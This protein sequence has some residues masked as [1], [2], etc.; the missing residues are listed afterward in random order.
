MSYRRLTWIG[1][2]AAILGVVAV[3]GA[4]AQERNPGPEGPAAA[5]DEQLAYAFM[6][7]SNSIAVIDL[8]G[9][10]ILARFSVAGNPHG[11]T[12]TPD[13]RFIYTASMGSEK[14]YVV[15]ARSGTTLKSIELGSISHHSAVSRDGRYVY[16]AADRVVVIDT[17][18][19]EVVERI[20]TEE[21]PFYLEFTPDGR[22]LFA[23]GVG[24]SIAVIDPSENRV[25]DTIRMPARS[26]MGHSAFRPDGKELYV[27]NDADDMV[28]VIDVESNKPV[29]SIPVGRGPHGVASTANG[30]FV[31]VAN[32]GGTMLS[33][34]DTESKAVVATPEVG[35][36]PEHLSSAPGGDVLLLSVNT[37]SNRILM[38]DPA[39]FETLAEIDVWPAPHTLV[40][41]AAVRTQETQAAPKL[42]ETRTTEDMAAGE[43]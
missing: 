8:A 12:I 11:G 33:V 37:G 36:R 31:V 17:A 3:T 35:R 7:G 19:N 10:A 13:G 42:I 24:S 2:L 6:D 43:P 29:A 18:S 21:P 26:V 22:R 41:S 16:V 40:F 28:S 27:T 5:S 32:R 30:R 20:A 15:D 14:I 38:I 1:F 34:I 9:K 39:S 4:Y 25:I 23:L